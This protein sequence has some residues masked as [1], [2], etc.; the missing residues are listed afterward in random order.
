MTQNLKAGIWRSEPPASELVVQRLLT[1]CG[2][3]LPKAYVDQLRRSNGGEGDL[4]LEPGW[5]SFWPAEEVVELN[6]AY[7][8]DESLPGFFGFGSNGGGELFA[9]KIVSSNCW[10]V[11]MIPF[12]P[13]EEAYAVLI[14]Q[15]CETFLRAVGREKAG[16]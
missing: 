14:A 2:L 4:A 5:V 1:D 13:M 7:E 10:P 8:I 3:D 15:D 6:R 16:Y 12:T 9:F 11:Y